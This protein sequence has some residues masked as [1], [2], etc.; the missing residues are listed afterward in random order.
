MTGAGCAHTKKSMGERFFVGVHAHQSA[1]EGTRDI[2]PMT[3][4]ETGLVASHSSSFCMQL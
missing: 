4:R 3:R 2:K 1:Q